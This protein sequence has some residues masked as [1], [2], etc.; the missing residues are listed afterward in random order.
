[1]LCLH[2]PR[3][4]FGA[5]KAFL[6]GSA[7]LTPS[8]FHSRGR[9]RGCGNGGGFGSETRGRT[10]EKIRIHSLFILGGQF[11]RVGTLLELTF[12]EACV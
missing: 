10:V 3:V 6:I 11:A 7:H 4:Q 5:P 9:R 1:M 2:K 12:A 8:G